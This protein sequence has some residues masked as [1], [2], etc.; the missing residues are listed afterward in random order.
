ME[1]G[2]FT[3]FDLPMSQAKN[4]IY[5]PANR[6]TEASR[7]RARPRKTGLG[8][9]VSCRHHPSDDQSRL[10]SLR[11]ELVHRFVMAIEDQQAAA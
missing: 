10:A 3:A 4:A 5:P 8:D 11:G 1:H 7:I 6:Q 9:D 2:S